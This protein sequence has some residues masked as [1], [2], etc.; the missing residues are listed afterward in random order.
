MLKY[1]SP[2]NLDRWVVDHTKDLQ[3]PVGNKQIWSNSDLVCTVV[4][5]PNQ[6]SDFH[7]DPFEEYF[8]QTRGTAYLLICDREKYERI[9]LNEGDV[10][11]LPPHILHS[12]QRPVPGS[13]CTVIERNRPEGEKDAFE[14]HCAC[15]GATVARHA[16]QLT[17]IVSDLPKVF[18]N[19]YS[20][21]V[22]EKTCSRCGELHPGKDWMQWHITL[23]THH[24]HAAIPR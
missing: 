14:W 23:A 21:D 22:T 6:R 16:L 15:C 1:G 18:S 19:F 8:H 5:G 4:G 11:L 12:P 7:D 3:P 10:F 2:L 17:S 13:L 20:S 9:T 24:R